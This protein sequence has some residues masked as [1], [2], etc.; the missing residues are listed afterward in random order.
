MYCSECGSNNIE[1]AKYCS[2]CG[3]KLENGKA[4]NDEIKDVGVGETVV[5]FNATAGNDEKVDTNGLKHKPII[6]QK[7]QVAIIISAISIIVVVVTCVVGVFIY[8]STH[9]PKAV[10]VNKQVIESSGISFPDSNLEK[11]VREQIKK[12]TGNILKGDVNKITSLRADEKNITNLS[13]IENLTNMTE[14]FLNKNKISNIEPLKKLIKL[15]ALYITDNQIS[16][17]EALKGLTN[18]TKLSLENNNIKDYTPV[19][20]YY[21]KLINKDFNIKR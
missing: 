12:T 6:S 10:S 20:V 5:D 2:K 18:M 21:K 3:I 1:G 14:L 9:K 16:H 13:G 15:T 19:K 8:E 4:V 17:T 7:K 11:V